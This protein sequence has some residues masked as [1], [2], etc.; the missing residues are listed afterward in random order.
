MRNPRPRQ[1]AADLGRPLYLQRQHAQLDVRLNPPGRPLE[2][3]P[4]FQPGLFHAPEAGFDDP[5]A[6]VT[7]C[8][9]LGRERVIVGD[10]HELAVELR[11]RLDLGGIKPRAACSVGC[12]VAAIAARGQQFA[13]RLRMIRLALA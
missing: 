1:A 4:H 11:R 7:K 9:V 10:D 8:D 5:T 6:F 12:Q 13:G 2:H 3:R